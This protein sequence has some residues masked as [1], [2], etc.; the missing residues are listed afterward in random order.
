MGQENILERG[1]F[2]NIMKIF[3]RKEPVYEYEFIYNGEK[4]IADRCKIRFCVKDE[5]TYGNVQWTR[6]IVGYK[7]VDYTP[8]VLSI[9]LPL[10]ISIGFISLVGI[11]VSLSKGT[12]ATKI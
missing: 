12:E 9:V 5:R 10:L 8:L 11:L 4:M 7:D 3:T 2:G 1:V 6:Q